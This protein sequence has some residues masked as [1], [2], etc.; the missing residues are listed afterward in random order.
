MVIDSAMP[1][2]SPASIGIAH[3]PSYR[4]WPILR[5]CI[6]RAAVG[7]LPSFHYSAQQTLSRW[8]IALDCSFG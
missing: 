1:F 6:R 5:A 2:S 7:P 8:A 4:A 3:G